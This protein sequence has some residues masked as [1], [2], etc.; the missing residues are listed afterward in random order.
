M[1]SKWSLIAICEDDD[2]NDGDNDENRLLPLL[3]IGF[4]YKILCQNGWNNEIK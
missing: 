1:H 2:D 4:A 3:E